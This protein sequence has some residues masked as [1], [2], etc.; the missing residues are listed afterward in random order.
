MKKLLSIL[1]ILSL[2]LLVGCG[3][4]SGP[5]NQEYDRGYLAYVDG[6]PEA[7]FKYLSKTDEIGVVYNL[8]TKVMYS[9]SKGDYNRG[10]M[11]PLYNPDGS[12]MIYEGEE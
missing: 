5:S 4:S 11:T 9:V 6:R 2:L 12:L 1:L 8:K 7:S 10:V 3:D